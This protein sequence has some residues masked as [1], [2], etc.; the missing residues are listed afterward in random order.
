MGD[1]VQIQPGAEGQPVAQVVF[2][3]DLGATGVT[4]GVDLGVSSIQP[5][6]QQQ[7]TDAA[8]ASIPI[9]PPPN[10]EQF[11]NTVVVAPT[12]NVAAFKFEVNEKLNKICVDMLSKWAE[13]IQEEAER[14]KAELLDPTEIRKNEEKLNFVQ[15]VNSYGQSANVKEDAFI[16]IM[17]VGL[18]FAS[19]SVASGAVF[20]LPG[21]DPIGVMPSR[22]QNVSSMFFANYSS[23]MRAELGL[24]GAAM[25]QGT[26]YLAVA[27]SLGT[28]AK[29]NAEGKDTSQVSAEKYTDSVITLVSSGQLTSMVTALVTQN[30]DP[31]I[32]ADPKKTEEIVQSAVKALKITLLMTALAALY[33]QGKGGT[34]RIMGQELEG[35]F[36][37]T[38]QTFGPNQETMNKL[39]GMIQAE[40][41]DSQDFASLLNAIYNYVDDPKN[42]TLASLTNPAKVLGN[43]MPYFSRSPVFEKG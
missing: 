27:Q 26:L 16:P 33:A 28:N 15:V 6:Q 20:S 19:N 11:V 4:G 7:E 12:I 25:L 2:T 38:N 18:L 35:L 17:T 34:E 30:I 13:S 24:L 1:D 36:N 41:G 23:D 14:R 8:N 5:S 31:S 40:I 9:L 42:N 10:F 37:G 21:N 3:P 32:K 29:G 43:L 22:D 39:I